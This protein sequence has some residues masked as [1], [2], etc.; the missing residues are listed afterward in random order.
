MRNDAFLLTRQEELRHAAEWGLA[1][2]ACSFSPEHSASSRDSSD[3][4][5]GCVSQVLARVLGPEFCPALGLSLPSF[6][7]GIQWSTSHPNPCFLFLWFQWP[8]KPGPKILSGK[9]QKQFISLNFTPFCVVWWNF[10]QSSSVPPGIP[11]MAW[12]SKIAQRWPSMHHQ[13]VNSNL[14]LHHSAY[15]IH[16]TSSQHEAFHHLTSSQEK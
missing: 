14:T 9:F 12:W 4:S 7:K 13:K 1:A 3:L 11:T 6:Y 10:I 15:V 2:Y 5:R 8:I 16:F